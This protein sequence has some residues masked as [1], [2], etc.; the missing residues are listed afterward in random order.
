MFGGWP[1]LREVWLSNVKPI[2]N[3]LP[4]GWSSVR[5]VLGFGVWRVWRGVRGVS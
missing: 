5:D 3:P 1:D 2:G 4:Q